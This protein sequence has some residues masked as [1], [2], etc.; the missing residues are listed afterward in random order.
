MES[1]FI[2]IRCKYVYTHQG[3]KVENQRGVLKKESFKENGRLSPHTYHLSITEANEASNT[4]SMWR[5]ALDVRVN[6]PIT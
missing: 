3:G 2:N 5:T 1:M 6:D 4:D